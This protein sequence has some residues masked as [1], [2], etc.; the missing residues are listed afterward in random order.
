[1]RNSDE[2]IGDILEVAVKVSEQQK[3]ICPAIYTSK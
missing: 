3:P 2:I 1:M